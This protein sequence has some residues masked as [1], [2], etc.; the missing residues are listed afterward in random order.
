MDTVEIRSQLRQLRHQVL[1][2]QWLHGKVLANVD[3][4]SPAS[5]HCESIVETPVA[6]VTPHS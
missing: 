5:G 2:L 3:I 6:P 4:E 1:H